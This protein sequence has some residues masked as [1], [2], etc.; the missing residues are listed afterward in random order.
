MS[1]NIRF[2]DPINLHLTMFN[3]ETG[4]IVL[5]KFNPLYSSVNDIIK[6]FA[7]ISDTDVF[8]DPNTILTI[9]TNDKNAVVINLVETAFRKPIR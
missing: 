7:N 6:I 8:V 3:N 9:D 4:E 5:K 1:F 2:I